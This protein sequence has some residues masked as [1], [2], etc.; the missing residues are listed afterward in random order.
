MTTLTQ[1][2]LRRGDI[3]DADMGDCT[4]VYGDDALERPRTCPRNAD[5]LHC[6]REGDPP[7]CRYCGKPQ[8]RGDSN[9]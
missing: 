2:R 3:D 9:E 5:D 8:N 6:V 1:Y 4:L 7:R